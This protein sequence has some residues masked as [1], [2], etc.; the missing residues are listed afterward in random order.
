MEWSYIE[1]IHTVCVGAILMLL[2]SFTHFSFSELQ[3]GLEGLIGDG[4]HCLLWYGF[5]LLHHICKLYGKQ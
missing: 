4:R 3:A 5:V 1:I 2:N